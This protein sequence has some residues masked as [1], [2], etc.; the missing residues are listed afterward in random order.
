M[1]VPR[2]SVSLGSMKGRVDLGAVWFR[3]FSLKKKT[4][5]LSMDWVHL[6]EG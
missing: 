2:H 3:L 1:G 4:C 5:P 6:T